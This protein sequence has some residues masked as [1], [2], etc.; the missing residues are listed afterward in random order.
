MDDDDKVRRNLTVFSASVLAADY[1]GLQLGEI[2]QSTLHL[3]HPVSPLKL[4]IA[5]LTVLAYL[6]LRYKDVK[7]M[8]D[9]T[10]EEAVSFNLKLVTPIV[11]QSYAQ[12]MLRLYKWTGY[13]S[14]IFEISLKDYCHFQ[15]AG[16]QIAE[17]QNRPTIHLRG[18]GLD[19]VVDGQGRLIPVKQRVTE[20]WAAETG[21]VWIKGSLRQETAGGR[22]LQ[23]KPKGTHL[24]LIWIYSRV[25]WFLFTEGAVR[26]R[27]PVIVGLAAT[28]ALERKIFFS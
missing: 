17:D 22:Q 26:A 27:I 28:L 12:F 6:G 21:I 23:I 20:T 19:N 15:A 18:L 24:F 8:D 1:F 25:W 4:S 16:L 2:V 13:E 7:L 14:S 3:V 10:Y 11:V 9:L 5:G